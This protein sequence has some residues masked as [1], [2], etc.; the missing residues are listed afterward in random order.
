MSFDI[1]P[2]SLYPLVPAVAG[3]PAVL[4]AGAQVFDT[5]TLGFLGAGDLVN[6]II[7]SEPVLWGVFDANGKSIADFD[8]VV[9]MNYRN[10]T[11]VS[12]Y[13]VENGTFASYNKVSDPFTIQVQ[14]ACGGN[15]SR[16][17]AFQADLLAAVKSI[18]LYTVVAEDGTFNNCNLVSV[19]WGRSSQDGAH[20][21]KAF[22][23]F[24]EIRQRGT[25]AFSQTAEPSGAATFNQGQVQTVD[26]PTIDA[27]GLA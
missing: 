26:D 2:K 15:L 1:V 22:C 4:R 7:G 6:S 14:L 8:S 17:A 23:E 12:D 5:L 25:T 11:R 20:I 27:T 18:K 19:D 16:R 9:S 10:D 13:P 21:V 24:R 3:V